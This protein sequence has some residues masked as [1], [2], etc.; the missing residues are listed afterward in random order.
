MDVRRFSAT[1]MHIDWSCFWITSLSVLENS[2][3]EM[4]S[5]DMLFS[6]GWIHNLRSEE[7]NDVFITF[8]TAL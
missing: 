4:C 2:R 3:N 1:A 5:I 8:I 7:G 6:C